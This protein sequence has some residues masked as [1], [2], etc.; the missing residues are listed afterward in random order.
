MANSDMIKLGGMFGI[1]GEEDIQDLP[2]I[3][4]VPRKSH[5]FRPSSRAKRDIIKDSI[6][7]HGIIQP[8]IVRPA[9]DCAYEILGKYEILAGHQRTELSR[10]LG[11]TTIPAI[12]KSG[13]SEADAEQYVTITNIQRSWEE[14][15]HSERA[16]IITEYYK[17]VK[18]SNRQEGVLGEINSYL[19]TYSSPVNT[20]A[21]DGLSQIATNSIRD[22]AEEYDLSK[23]MIA[24]YIRIYTLIEDI[25]L[26]IDD[27]EI[28]L[29]AGVEL[30][31][32]NEE[33]QNLLVE[34]MR[35]NEYKCD[36]RKAKLI[37]ELQQKAKLTASIMLE[38]LSGEKTKKAPGKPKPFKVSGT[39]FNK[40]FQPETKQKEIDEIIDKA[41]ELYFSND[42]KLQDKTKELYQENKERQEEN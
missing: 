2:I 3:S 10:E 25:K 12:V 6:K 33:N 29:M 22:V 41:L 39:I 28:P 7:E 26:M 8:I 30:S 5:R 14:L 31:Y 34:L 42:T 21:G 16:A 19:Q 20:R 35:A 18:E 13:L 4:L 32:I 9:E 36:I 37:R 15:N 40:Y 1:G 27:K 17:A 38:V 23:D 11:N 24:R